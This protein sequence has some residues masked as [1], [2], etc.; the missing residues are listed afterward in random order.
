MYD[1]YELPMGL[2]LVIIGSGLQFLA[3]AFTLSQIMGVIGI[4]RTLIQTVADG[5]RRLRGTR[6]AEVHVVAARAY[7][8]G[9]D[10]AKVIVAGETDIDRLNRVVNGLES[11]VSDMDARIVDLGI[12]TKWELDDRLSQLQIDRRKQAEKDATLAW[13]GV[14]C[15]GLG[16]VFQVIGSVLQ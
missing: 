15:V 13:W 9:T 6:S 12:R 11:R 3:L 16:I 14:V 4:R 10:H 8:H 1:W 5:Y 2:T 7:G